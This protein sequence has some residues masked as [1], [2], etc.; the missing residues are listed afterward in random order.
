MVASLVFCEVDETVHLKVGTMGLMDFLSGLTTGRMVLNSGV[1][2]D[3]K[4][5]QMVEE[6][7][8]H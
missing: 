2:S 8:I 1:S 7:A 5:L 3:W 4:A 6:L